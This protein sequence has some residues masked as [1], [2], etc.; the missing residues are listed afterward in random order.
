[1]LTALLQRSVSCA[2]EARQIVR[3]ADKQL[4]YRFAGAA[5]FTV[6]SCRGCD[7]SRGLLVLIVRFF[8]NTKS[9]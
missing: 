2:A 3:S 1:M 9:G 8:L 6:P 7:Y 5:C 4:A